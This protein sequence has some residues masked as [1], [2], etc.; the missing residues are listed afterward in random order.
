MPDFDK[1]LAKQNGMSDAA[2][3]AADSIKKN[4]QEGQIKYPYN[5]SKTFACGHK[6]EFNE[7]EENEYINLRHGT[8]GAY[9][10]TVSYTHLRAHET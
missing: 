9:I 7:T 6:W 3:E 1:E 10:K 8:T 5:K 2:I 4:Q